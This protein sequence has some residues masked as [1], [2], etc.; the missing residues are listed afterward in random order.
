VRRA[1]SNC[2]VKE[3]TRGGVGRGFVSPE[4]AALRRAQVYRWP[5]PCVGGVRPIVTPVVASR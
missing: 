3:P 5:G 4:A 2:V 1:G